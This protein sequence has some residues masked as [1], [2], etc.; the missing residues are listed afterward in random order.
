[1]KKTVR[2]VLLLLLQCSFLCSFCQ[3]IDSRVCDSAVRFPITPFTS[4]LRTTQPIGIDS[5]LQSQSR[6]IRAEN[7][8]VLVF[9]YDPYYYWVRIIVENPRYESNHLMLLMAPYGLYDGK[10]YKKQNSSWKEVAHTGLKYKFEDRSY[11]F[12]HHVFPFTL[13]QK[14]TDTL[15]LSIDASNA[16]KSFGFALLKPKE[17]KMFENKIYFVFGIIVGLLILFFVLNVSLFFAMK[18]RLHIWYALY[19]FL[20]FLIVMKNDLLDQQF[21]GLDSEKAFRFTP[22]M[23]IG[24]V[25][26]AVLMHV[27]QQFLKPVLIQSKLLRRLTQFLKINVLCSAAVHFAVFVAS[28]DYRV[29]SVVF[30]WAK[31]STFLGI[32]IIIINCIYCIRRGFKGAW[33]IVFGSFVFM[34]GSVQRLYFPSTLS[35][36]F[37]PTTFHIGI[38]VETFV[39]SMALIYRIWAERLRANQIQTQTLKDVSEEIHDNVGHKLALAQQNLEMIDHLQQKKAEDGIGR[40]IKQIKESNEVLRHLSRTMKN[41]PVQG[42]SMIEKI[43]DLCNEMKEPGLYKVDFTI[44]GMRYDFENQQQSNIIGIL[45][46]IFKNILKHSKASTVVVSFVFELKNLRI[47]VYD[48]GVGFEVLKVKPKSNGLQN[49]KNRCSSLNAA[50][51]I[52]S[53]P[54]EGTRI[55]IIVPI[56]E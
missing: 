25:A 14:I 28:K 1:M 4:Y 9:N 6:F 27:V 36:L 26:I 11:Q 55:C 8:P 52:E 19:I 7:K 15:Y 37:P 31:I 32:C 35:F 22:Y 53:K 20:L 24:A 34:F 12:T 33:F 39:I 38:I 3:V 13:E 54:G 21:L 29:E 42:K 16:Y 30:S 48:D 23:T 56:E 45:K 5:V 46:G 49:I 40:A 47:E 41:E 51:Q 10:L 17:L 18:E 44:S 50:F 43:Q 2:L